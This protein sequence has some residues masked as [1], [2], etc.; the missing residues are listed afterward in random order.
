VQRKR[1]VPETLVAFT[2]VKVANQEGIGIN[3]NI[4]FE[5]VILN[6]GNGFHPN[7]GVFIASRRGVY[8]IT[9]SLVH[10]A[11]NDPF[12]GALVLNGNIIVRLHGEHT[13]WDQ[14]S[15]TVFLTLAPGDEVFVRNIDIGNENVQGNLWSSFS[16]F[17]LWEL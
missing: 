13:I 8:L 10:S 17:L 2:A 5:K 16:G 11:Q 6:E 15:Q 9:V 4:L 7:Q 12:H 1:S 14:T 3:Q